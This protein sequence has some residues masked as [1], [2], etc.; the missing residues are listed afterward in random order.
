MSHQR[1]VVIVGAGIAGLAT[2][3]AMERAGWRVALLER[4]ERLKGDQASLTLQPNAVRALRALGLGLVLDA[5]A[6]PL[7]AG[8]LRR[9]DGHLLATVPLSE[10]TAR[11]GPQPVAVSRQELF[12]G[13]VAALGTNVEVHSGVTA[14]HL[15]LVESAAGDASRRWPAD[16]IVGAD[17]IFSSVRGGIDDT[18]KVESAGSVVFRAVIPSHRVPDL[19]DQGCHTQGP[20][21]RRFWYEPLPRGASWTAIVRGGPR[22]EP[23]HVRHE[24]LSEWFD[25]WHDP[26]PQ[27]IA[28]TRPEEVQQERVS[29]LRPMPG[30]YTQMNDT[31]GAALVGDAAHAML[32]ELRQGAGLALEDAVTLG[33]CLTDKP[34]GDGLAEYERQR[35]ERTTRL[36]KVALRMGTVYSGRGR[37]GASIRDNLLRAVPDSVYAKHATAGSDWMPPESH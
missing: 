34:L 15:D 21:R 5:I 11:L 8:R 7:D 13:L 26:I 16:L 2:A 27:L 36:A 18:S 1:R 28:A 9:H 22:P 29:Y 14:T 25:G 32:P 12:E 10:T 6:L 3:I 4:N 31:C 17:G 30:V 33:A 19:P 35:Y 20:N 24:L 23:A 37:F